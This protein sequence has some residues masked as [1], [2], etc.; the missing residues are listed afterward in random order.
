MDE[1]V[2]LLERLRPRIERLGG[3][4]DDGEELYAEVS[5]ACVE[6]EQ[7]YDWSHPKIDG[8]V[9]AMAENLR[10]TRHRRERLR[11]HACLRAEDS[12]AL[13]CTPG[14]IDE[15]QSRV[16]IAIRD[17]VDRLPDRYREVVDE[18]S[19][20]GKRMS[21]IARAMG[22][23]PATIRTHWRRALLQLAHDPSIRDLWLIEG[24]NGK[25]P[26]GYERRK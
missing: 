2:R 21:A 12:Q 24:D 9:I 8:R 25:V 3:G 5:L 14:S 4:K 13:A 1:I 18:H 11:K 16:C 6:K 19:F 22:L 17:A 23:P 10:I 20:R 26:A 15:T 7:R